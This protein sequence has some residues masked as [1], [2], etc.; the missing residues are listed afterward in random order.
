MTYDID[1]KG[2][3]TCFG[4][5]GLGYGANM[6]SPIDL[7]AIIKK[8]IKRD[9]FRLGDGYLSAEEVTKVL[10]VLIPEFDQKLKEAY[11]KWKVDYI[12]GDIEFW[13]PE[14]TKV[15]QRE[16]TNFEVTKRMILILLVAN[17]K[18]RGVHFH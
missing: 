4:I 2:K 14:K 3:E 15:Q 7:W 17:F 10:K 6:S 1:L 5:H 11:K 16:K 18:K 12:G 8:A 13:F 9:N